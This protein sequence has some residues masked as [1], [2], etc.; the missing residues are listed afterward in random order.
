M[1]KR[2]PLT[3]Y[4]NLFAR[5]AFKLWARLDFP[6]IPNFSPS[7]LF[8]SLISF[9]TFSFPCFSLYDRVLYFRDCS[10]YLEFHPLFFFSLKVINI[11]AIGSAV[12]EE[13][14][15]EIQMSSLVWFGLEHALNFKCPL[16]SLSGRRVLACILLYTRSLSFTVSST[17]LPPPS[18]FSPFRL[19]RN[20]LND[21][22][23]KQPPWP[24]A[25]SVAHRVLAPAAS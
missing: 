14:R 17:K 3:S 10:L 18:L 23:E 4:P 12:V 2:T 21:T 13:A 16:L 24:L 20:R 22:V 7:L 9:P 5:A 15:R 25:H 19:C 11:R 8:Y 1:W 6:L